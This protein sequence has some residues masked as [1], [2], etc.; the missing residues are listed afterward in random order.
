[1]KTLALASLAPLEKLATKTPNFF[2]FRKIKKNPEIAAKNYL[3]PKSSNYRI[4]TF[5]NQEKFAAKTPN[6]FL[7]EKLKKKHQ[8]SGEKITY[9]RNLHIST[10][11]PFQ[12][13]KNSP[14]K[15]P[16]FLF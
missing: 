12:I 13:E 1:L 10:L 9:L 8:N 16:I 14:L 5:S 2:H 6:F 15:R 11:E 7:S 4:S 3:L